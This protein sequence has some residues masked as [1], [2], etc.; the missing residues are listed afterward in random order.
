LAGL[1]VP[2]DDVLESDTVAGPVA[3]LSATVYGAEVT[4]A[5]SVEEPPEID[6]FGGGAGEADAAA[7]RATSTATR[8]AATGVNALRRRDVTS[9]RRSTSLPGFPASCSAT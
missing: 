7:T 9:L 6:S 5:W 3:P 1:K 8:S 2:V 4:P